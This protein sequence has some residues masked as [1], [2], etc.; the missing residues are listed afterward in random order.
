MPVDKFSNGS[1]FECHN[2][3]GYIVAF[4]VDSNNVLEWISM[5]DLYKYGIYVDFKSN[6]TSV[7]KSRPNGASEVI[8]SVPNIINLTPDNFQNKIK[9]ILTFS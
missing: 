5:V 8:F 7:F 9:T 3:D 4:L 1:L 2:H 6:T